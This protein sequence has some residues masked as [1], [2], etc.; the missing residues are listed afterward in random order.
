MPGTVNAKEMI[1]K[2]LNIWITVLLPVL[3]SLKVLNSNDKTLLK[4]W[5][6][7]LTVLLL[8]TNLETCQHFESF[9]EQHVPF[10]KYGILLTNLWIVS[11]YSKG[12]IVLFN[13]FI[14][15]LF[16][17]YHDFPKVMFKKDNSTVYLNSEK[18]YGLNN[19][20]LEKLL[21]KMLQLMHRLILCSLTATFGFGKKDLY[22]YQSFIK[23]RIP[24]VYLVFKNYYDLLNG[25]NSDLR[26]LRRR[27]Q[28]KIMNAI[29][30][31]V[32]SSPNILT[33]M[34]KEYIEQR[35]TNFSKYGGN[36]NL[37]HNDK[38]LEHFS[39]FKEAFI[40]N[41]IIIPSPNRN[42][43]VE[44]FI[45]QYKEY[46]NSPLLFNISLSLV[47]FV[48]NFLSN[49][50]LILFYKTFRIGIN[51]KQSN[52]LFSMNSEEEEFNSIGLP[53][54]TNVC[55]TNVVDCNMS[56]SKNANSTE[57][58][59]REKKFSNDKNSQRNKVADLLKKKVSFA[60]KDTLPSPS[61]LLSPQSESTTDEYQATDEQYQSNNANQHAP[62][63]VLSTQKNEEF[64]AK[65]L[66]PSYTF[67][68]YPAQS[69]DNV[70]NYDNTA[71]T[72]ILLSENKLGKPRLDQSGVLQVVLSPVSKRRNSIKEFLKG[73]NRHGLS[74]FTNGNNN[75]T[76][77]NLVSFDQ[78]EDSFANSTAVTSSQTGG[79]QSLNSNIVHSF[80]NN[81]NNSRV[82]TIDEKRENNSV[83][84]NNLFLK[85]LNDLPCGSSQQ[86][87]KKSSSG[88][89]TINK[90]YG[91]Q[92]NALSVSLNL[93]VNS[94]V[95]INPHI[96]EK[97]LVS[98]ISL[99]SNDHNNKRNFTIDS[100]NIK[101]AHE[102]MMLMND[103]F[104]AILSQNENEGKILPDHEGSLI[105]ERK[106]SKEF[107]E[108]T[109]DNR[110]GNRD[111]SMSSVSR[112]P[113]RKHGLHFFKR[114]KSIRN[115]LDAFVSGEDGFLTLDFNQVGKQF[116]PRVSF[117][118]TS[119]R[120]IDNVFKSIR[121]SIDGNTG[122][123]NDDTGN[124]ESREIG[125]RQ[126]TDLLQ[127][128]G[129]SNVAH[130]LSPERISLD[131]PLPS[132]FGTEKTE[133]KNAN[134]D[135]Y[136]QLTGD[137]STSKDQHV[138]DR[139]SPADK[140]KI[141]VFSI[142]NMDSDNA[143][144]QHNKL[145]NDYNIITDNTDDF[146][147]VSSADSWNDKD[148][149]AE[150]KVK[151][152]NVVNTP[153][154]LGEDSNSKLKSSNKMSDQLQS[155]GHDPQRSYSSVGVEFIHSFT[156]NINKSHGFNSDNNVSFS[157]RDTIDYLSY[158]PSN[159]AKY[160]KFPLIEM[161]ELNSEADRKKGKLKKGFFSDVLTKRKYKKSLSGDSS[162]NLVDTSN[163]PSAQ[164][165]QFEKDIKTQPDHHKK[166]SVSHVFRLKSKLQ[167]DSFDSKNVGNL[168]PQMLFRNRNSSVVS[169]S[170]DPCTY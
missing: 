143:G 86:P 156:P 60:T 81:I 26:I 105:G 160:S 72:S 52:K 63:T 75:S 118:K 152:N 165:N 14:Q 54:S 46:A 68:T 45:L 78:T 64:I 150:L 92:H 123:N 18:L 87:K 147:S 77:R 101:D 132:V 1:L 17:K 20:F 76:K 113:E 96:S 125:N 9:Y 25:I 74:R 167:R 161:P 112:S 116:D 90:I 130:N 158:Q 24:I 19:L 89:L 32:N 79:N 48:Y 49:Y 50:A 6:K 110:K 148:E 102:K 51:D 62:D 5:L 41:N 119:R 42:L 3:A 154:F 141:A 97:E 83:I 34:E 40:Q 82:S 7:L 100:G 145:N 142:P 35:Q 127:K 151:M 59:V 115:S 61:K 157:D 23:D 129:N 56:S 53:I 122:H 139:N 91:D 104:G 106:V 13:Q 29:C 73:G 28:K 169:Y 166:R 85:S 111:Q 93:K 103:P 11:P 71:T 135:T 69:I 16:S 162:M 155:K 57:I 2:I 67:K 8:V 58:P 120:S 80:Y 21:D 107:I 33:K 47:L 164:A 84:S 126:D 128:V 168:K 22:F 95:N 140:T 15:P 124:V 144:N 117:E 131:K 159:T 43:Y 39:K 27:Y 65:K 30:H 10:K 55:S 137:K 99:D 121:K 66:L 114:N 37:G 94:L 133:S 98:P 136:L 4:S 146:G 70:L 138:S 38:S 170:E 149:D 36:Q 44:R 109:A 153:K 88:R 134:M 12:Y 108:N 163:L 31:A